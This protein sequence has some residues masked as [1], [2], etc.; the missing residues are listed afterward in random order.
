MIRLSY[1]STICLTLFRGT[2]LGFPFFPFSNSRWWN[3]L[4]CISE[5]FWGLNYV[6]ILVNRLLNVITWL[7]SLSIFFLLKKQSL[8]S[9]LRYFLFISLFILYYIL[10]IIS[11]SH[12]GMVRL[13]SEFK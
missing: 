1:S 6:F 2:V 10:Y 7:L 3:W 5:L 8:V 12:C 13:N 9:F 4:V 11:L